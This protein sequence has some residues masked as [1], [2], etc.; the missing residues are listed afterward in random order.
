MGSD[1]PVVAADSVLETGSKAGEE[2]VHGYGELVGVS[3][4]GSVDLIE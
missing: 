2:A 1:G 4:D 3:W